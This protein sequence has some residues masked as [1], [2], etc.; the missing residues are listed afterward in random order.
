MNIV[1]V[2]EILFKMCFF[3]KYLQ[4]A[5]FSIGH[6]LKIIQFQSIH[7]SQFAEPYFCLS[8]HFMCFIS[9]QITR[10]I[11]ICIRQSMTSLLRKYEKL[12]DTGVVAG[13]RTN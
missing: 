1:L 12:S 4:M 9:V 7:F 6:F 8:G 5:F 11:I 13:A 3:Y 2:Y 10:Y